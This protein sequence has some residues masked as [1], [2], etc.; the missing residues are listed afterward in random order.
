MPNAWLSP[1]NGYIFRITHVDNLRW[2]LR[3][4]LHC[5]SSAARDPEFVPIGNPEI[6]ASRIA[7]EVPRPPGGTLADYVPFYFTPFSPMAFN[8]RTGH[9][10]IVRQVRANEIA[11]LV[12]SV[13][14]LSASGSRVLHTDRHAFLMTARFFDSPSDLDQ[15][16]WRLLRERDFRRDNN[17]PGKIE[18]YQAEALVHHQLPADRLRAVLCYCE[19]QRRRVAHWASEANCTVK[20]AVDSRFYFA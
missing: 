13:H 17:D 5:Q 6:I 14:D 4:G 16:D 7:R 11:I 18:R 20:V 15:V 19:R 9:R 10:D 12:A 2:T 1:E 3:N 8:V